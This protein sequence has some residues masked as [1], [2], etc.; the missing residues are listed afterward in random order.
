MSCKD[1]GCGGNG[2]CGRSNKECEEK[3]EA[4]RKQIGLWKSI[5]TKA[6]SLDGTSSGPEL[7]SDEEALVRKTLDSFPEAE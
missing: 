7:T 3:A 4:S 2:E 5:F 6:L 1:G